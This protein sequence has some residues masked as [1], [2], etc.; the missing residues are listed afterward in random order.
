M[1]EVQSKATPNKAKIDIQFSSY[2]DIYVHIYIYL[3]ATASALSYTVKFFTTYWTSSYEDH[4]H[5]DTVTAT[6]QC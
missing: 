3:L 1:L 4:C 6:G 2:L 5:T